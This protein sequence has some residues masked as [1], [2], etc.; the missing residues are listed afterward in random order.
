MRSVNRAASFVGPIQDVQRAKGGRGG[1]GRERKKWK[2][3]EQ[4]KG[5]RER[6]TERLTRLYPRRTTT[7]PHFQPAG[8]RTSSHKKAPRKGGRGWMLL[9]FVRFIYHEIFSASRGTEKSPSRTNESYIAFIAKWSSSG[10]CS[11]R[12][13]H[14]PCDLALFPSLVRLPRQRRRRFPRRRRYETTNFS[15]DGTILAIQLPVSYP[16]RPG[17]RM[18][19]VEIFIVRRR[20]RRRGQAV[21]VDGSF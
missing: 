19:I 5:V 15:L 11:R 9:E 20:W 6:W 13:P 14:P 21:R 3:I 7:W 10:Y 2:G 4:G 12:S 8:S 16:P 18:A 1:Q 17:Y